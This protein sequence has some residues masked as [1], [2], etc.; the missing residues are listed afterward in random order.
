MLKKL[1]LGNR[2]LQ[3][4]WWK[5]YKLSIKGLNYDRGHVPSANGEEFALKYALSAFGAKENIVLFDVGAN[6]GQYL[7][8]AKNAA[9]E[10][11]QIYCFEPQSSAFAFLEKSAVKYQNVVIENMGLGEG[12]AV[13]NLFADSDASEY[14]SLYPANYTQYNVN[15][16]RKEE[17]KIDSLDNYCNL[18]GIKRINFLKIDVEGHEI[19]VLK[20]ASK[21]LSSGNIDFIQF[22]FGLAS[23]ESRVF[24][25]DFFAIL[26]EYTI[27]RILPNGLARIIYSEYTE[28]FLTTNYLAVLNKN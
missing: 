10:R 9:G 4:F 7:T 20:G 25:K 8:M 13:V 5:L 16:S 22:E 1:L 11:L 26:P 2:R 21:L 6:R 17:I 19:G 27:Y 12:P 28:L 18:H 24:L 23:I 3:N 14:A 15:L